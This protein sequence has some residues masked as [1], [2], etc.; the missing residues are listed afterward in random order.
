MLKINLTVIRR[1]LRTAIGACVAFALRAPKCK[2]KLKVWHSQLSWFAEHAPRMQ[3][4][5]RGS[6]AA[7]PH[8]TVSDY[9][10]VWSIPSNRWGRTLLIR[11]THTM[12]SKKEAG[13]DSLPKYGTFM[14]GQNDSFMSRDG[15]G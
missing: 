10:W 3:K 4:R 1:Y 9:Y 6:L 5:G 15:L 8:V 12:A 14:S 13:R 7:S 11:R 2:G